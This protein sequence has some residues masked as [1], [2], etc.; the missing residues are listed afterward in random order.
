MYI[1]EDKDLGMMRKVKKT[2]VPINIEKDVADIFKAAAKKNGVTYTSLL[3]YLMDQE[4]KKIIDGE[5]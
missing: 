2:Y 1:V 5:K 3:K 4:F